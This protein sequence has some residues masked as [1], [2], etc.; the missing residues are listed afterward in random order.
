MDPDPPFSR[1]DLAWLLEEIGELRMPFGK[2]G[3]ASCPPDGVPLYD[4][5]LDYLQW[6]TAK[7]FPAGRLGELMEIVC[8]TKADGA[9]VIFD[10]LRAQAGGRTRLQRPRR[11]EGGYRID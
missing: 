4:L 1:D 2:Y 9:D 3:P 8:Q 7:G 5:P 10:G 11:K 6:F